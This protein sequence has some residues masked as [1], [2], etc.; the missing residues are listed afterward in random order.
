MDDSRLILAGV[1]ALGLGA[2]AGFAID[3]VMVGA[4][5]SDWRSHY[6]RAEI[7][8]DDAAG[9]LVAMASYTGFGGDAGRGDAP[10]GPR[11]S[12]HGW[13]GWG[14]DAAPV[15]PADQ[16]LEA[17]DS[18]PEIAA[19]ELPTA[20]RDAV[21]RALEQTADIAPSAQQPVAAAPDN[22]Q[23]DSDGLD[24]KT[25]DVP[26]PGPTAADGGPA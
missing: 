9:D 21:G 17:A 8:V 10:A 14:N 18:A 15:P 6:P 4:P 23:P 3:P 20:G 19:S 2:L 7:A 5:Q 22:S 25:G 13:S 12:D 11:F 24:A 16:A 1:L 26:A